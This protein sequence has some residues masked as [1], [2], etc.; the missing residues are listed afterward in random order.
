MAFALRIVERI[1]VAA[2]LCVLAVSLAVALL[3]APWFTR[4]VTTRLN[5]ASQAGLAPSRA[6]QTAEQVRH[7]VTT[8]NSPALPA[9]VDGRSGFDRSAVEHLIDVRDVVLALRGASVA[10]AIALAIW[11]AVSVRARR[12]SHVASALRWGGVACLALPVLLAL[13]GLLDFE[14]LFASF[15]GVFFEAGTWT[16]PPD[17]LLIELFPERF[18]MTAGGALTLLVVLQGV[19]MWAA[20][21]VVET[22]SGSPTGRE[23]RSPA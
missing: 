20:G 19:A 11:L 3:T 5:V 16:F 15:H 17:S 13:A 7:F 8:A 22:R 21:R 23:K 9:Q 2:A 1:A 4:T 18:W 10:I 6:M 14:S 12:L